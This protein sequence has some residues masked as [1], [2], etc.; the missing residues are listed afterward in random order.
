MHYESIRRSKPLS[1]PVVLTFRTITEKECYAAATCPFV[2]YIPVET[3]FG[4]RSLSLLSR[5]IDNRN[6]LQW[7]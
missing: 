3:Q 2:G 7:P 4:G 1:N 6:K 5:P